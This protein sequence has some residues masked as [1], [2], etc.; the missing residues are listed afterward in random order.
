MMKFLSSEC[1]ETTCRSPQM[2]SRLV[3]LPLKLNSGNF[4]SAARVLT[5]YWA[6][7]QGAR[8]TS[9]TSAEDVARIRGVTPLSA[10]ARQHRVRITA[11]PSAQSKEGARS[12]VIT[13]GPGARAA[14]NLPLA[15]DGRN[16]V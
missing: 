3:S 14:G 4:L 16:H 8:K 2:C 10:P 9:A 7:L 5:T 15:M 13:L 6:A 1:R 12:K 11:G